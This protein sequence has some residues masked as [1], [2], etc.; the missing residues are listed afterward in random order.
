MKAQI[1]LAIMIL[2][3]ILPGHA[4]YLMTREEHAKLNAQIKRTLSIH[5][6]IQATVTV[7]IPVTK[8]YLTDSTHTKIDFSDSAYYRTLRHTPTYQSTVGCKA[9]ALDDHWLIAGAACLWN[10]RHT[11]NIG[12]KNYPTG[13]IEE[14]YSKIYLKVNGTQVPMDGNLFV[15]PRF[16]LLPHLMLVRIPKNSQLASAVKNMPKIHILSTMRTN[17]LNLKN[18]SFYVNTSRFGSDTAQLHALDSY[19][20]NTRTIT[21]REFFDDLAS[22]SNDPLL[23][24]SR[25]TIYWIGINDGVMVTYPNRKWDGKPSKNFITFDNCDLDFIQ[26]TISHQDPGAWARIA[27]RLH[28]GN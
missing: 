21:I 11:V 3:M 16:A 12:G 26:R 8:Q 24:V 27:P 14:D 20:T 1:T 18:G 22:L 13:L 28:R 17:P 7:E 25:G 2:G 6:K 4:Q 9:Y 5:N 15:Q 10:G 23:Y 19:N